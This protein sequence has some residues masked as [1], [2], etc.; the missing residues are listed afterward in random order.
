MGAAFG[1][2]S[3]LAPRA[4]L[5]EGTADQPSAKGVYVVTFPPPNECVNLGEIRATSRTAAL[6]RAVSKGGFSLKPATGG[7]TVWTI[8]EWSGFEKEAPEFI[9]EQ[10]KHC[11]LVGMRPEKPE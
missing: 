10:K 9:K 4:S 11:A 3:A 5:L 6:Y 8:E 7:L 1:Q 2:D